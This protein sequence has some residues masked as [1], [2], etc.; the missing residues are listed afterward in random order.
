MRFFFLILFQVLILN[1]INLG[2]YINP[3]YYV[4]FIL[5]LPFATPRWTLLLSAFFLGLGIDVFTNTP[6][7]NAAASVAMAF[8]RPYVII[9]LSS[10]TESLVGI[11]PAIKN[12]GIRWFFYYA[13]ILIIIHHTTLFYLEIFR[14]DEFFGTF[15]RSLLSSA[16]TLLLVLIS[17][18]LLFKKT[19]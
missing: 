15:F 5:L 4:Y 9:M 1:N 2:G 14:F 16:F 6:G 12:Q 19:K 18:Y 7:L 17:E 13:A 3:L 11:H 8:A 10:S